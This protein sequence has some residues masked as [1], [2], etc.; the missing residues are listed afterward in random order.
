MWVLLNVCGF[1]AS[2]NRTEQTDGEFSFHTRERDE[3]KRIRG[4]SLS[5]SWAQTSSLVAAGGLSP[6][7]GGAARRCAELGIR[8]AAI[9]RLKARVWMVHQLRCVSLGK[10]VL[11][12][13]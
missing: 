8:P 13:N 7:P 10:E 11:N 6:C 1:Q 3:Q 2:A 9:L 4:S 5:D 12:S